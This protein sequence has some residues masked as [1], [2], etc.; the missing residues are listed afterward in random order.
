MNNIKILKE[1]IEKIAKGG[2]FL[3]SIGKRL[4]YPFGTE[5]DTVYKKLVK[6][7]GKQKADDM[8]SL[9]DDVI[10]IKKSFGIISKEDLLNRYARS[11]LIG[12]PAIGAGISIPLGIAGHRKKKKN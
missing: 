2:S 7:I 10:D 5:R 3:K 6:E 1:E 8:G 11:G 12:I 9:I 4:W